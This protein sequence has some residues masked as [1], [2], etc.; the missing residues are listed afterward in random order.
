MRPTLRLMWPRPQ[1]PGADPILIGPFNARFRDQ[2]T[3]LGNTQGQSAERNAPIS[4]LRHPESSN[5]T[6]AHWGPQML[7]DEH[8]S[9]CH[10]SSRFSRFFDPKIRQMLI[11]RGILGVELLTTPRRLR[12]SR[13]SD[14]CFSFGLRRFSAAF[15]VSRF[16]LWA[17]IAFRLDLY[18]SP[19]CSI[20][21]LPKTNR[22][23][24]RSHVLASRC[25]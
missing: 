3:V 5:S 8:L 12:D 23:A 1:P 13:F 19:N 14:R 18:L 2:T 9:F 10:Y 22:H 20:G 11:T 7:I 4:F 15:F 16:F 17:Q 6:N 21:T 25:P 24:L